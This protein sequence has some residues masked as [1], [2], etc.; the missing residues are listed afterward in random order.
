VEVETD[1]WD[2]V[3]LVVDKLVK[4]KVGSDVAAGEEGINGGGVIR[5]MD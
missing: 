2:G 4:K 5:V 1:G 3:C